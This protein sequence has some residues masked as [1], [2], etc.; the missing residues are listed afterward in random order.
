VEIIF[1]EHHAVISERMRR[2]AEL[3]VRRAAAR[4]ARA[5]DAIIRFEQDG[6]VK[7]VEI[8]LHAP[9][10]RNIVVLAEDRF[11]GRALTAAISKLSAQVRKLGRARKA[12]VRKRAGIRERATRARREIEVVGA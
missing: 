2:R 10:Q 12:A 1:H 9:R 5:V 6:P 11:Y 7:R 8:V 3:A 4:L